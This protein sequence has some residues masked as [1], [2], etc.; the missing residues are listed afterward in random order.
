MIKKI[1]HS[2]FSSGNNTQKSRV[3]ELTIVENRPSISDFE[4]TELSYEEF[5]SRFL[6]EDR[7]KDSAY[8]DQERRNEAKLYSA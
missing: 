7:R 6:T 4:V 1:F 5:T 3:P 8:V 2:I